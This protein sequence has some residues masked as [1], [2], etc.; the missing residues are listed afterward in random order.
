MS[1]PDTEAMVVGLQDIKRKKELE[2][3][4]SEQLLVKRPSKKS[5]DDSDASQAL[6]SEVS[7]VH[8]SDPMSIQSIESPGT[9]TGFIS[10][11]STS[12]G[13]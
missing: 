8:P 2:E 11:S 12:S 6:R 9:P 7:S 4:Q 5:A 10:G 13:T 3:A 1:E